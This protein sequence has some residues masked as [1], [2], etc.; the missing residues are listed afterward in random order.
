MFAYEYTELMRGDRGPICPMSFAMGINEIRP[1]NSHCAWLV[2]V[3]EEGDLK[4]VCAMAAMAMSRDDVIPH[5][6]L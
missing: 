2:Q 4:L 1:C 6:D 3:G 5:N